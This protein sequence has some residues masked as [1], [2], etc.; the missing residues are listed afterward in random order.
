MNT[1]NI[2]TTTNG[3]IITVVKMHHAQP[4]YGLIALAI[5]GA[6]CLGSGL[7]LLLRK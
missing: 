1:T 4:H 6:V 7:Y 2:I 5:L 3:T